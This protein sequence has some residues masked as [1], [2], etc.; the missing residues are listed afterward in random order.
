MYILWHA[1][2]QNLNF[3]LALSDDSWLWIVLFLLLFFKTK[4]RQIKCKF[5]LEVKSKLRAIFEKMSS[6]H[7]RDWS[8]WIVRAREFNENEIKTH[9]IPSSQ[10]PETSELIR[11]YCK[12]HSI[13]INLMM[14][15]FNSRFPARNSHFWPRSLHFL[16]LTSQFI[17]AT[18]KKNVHLT[19]I[20]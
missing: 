10:D 15:I 6:K 16:T 1:V 8:S 7:V 2:A 11:K 20:N 14:A 18:L 17:S 19:I 5:V 13:L 9:L 3:R 12:F 4:N